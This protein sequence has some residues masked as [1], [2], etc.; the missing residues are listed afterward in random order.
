MHLE[1]DGYG[2]DAEKLKDV[3]LVFS[4]LDEYPSQIGMTKIIPPQVYTY[5]GQK[6][7]DW[8]V[9]GFVIIAESRISAHT[10]PDK[11]YFNIDAF[12]WKAFDVTESLEDLK[13]TFTIPEVKT[14][15]LDRGPEYTTS[16]NAYTGMVR[17]RVT[18]IPNA[19]STDA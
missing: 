3:D 12:S 5:R 4:F 8:G 9:S 16:R 10:F 6:P 11:G 1:I 13:S 14:W 17:A 19:G 7:E 2:C 15:E 18:L